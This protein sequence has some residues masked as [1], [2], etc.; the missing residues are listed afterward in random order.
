LSNVAALFL[1]SMLRRVPALLIFAACLGMRIRIASQRVP[2]PAIPAV[3]ALLPSGFSPILRFL[4]ATTSV[5]G[6]DLKARLE[7][8]A[9]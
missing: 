6:G 9:R 4:R 8:L 3:A 2:A 1:G 5:G 7:R